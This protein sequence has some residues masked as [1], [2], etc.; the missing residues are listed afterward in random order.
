MMRALD[1]TGMLY[2][3]YGGGTAFHMD[4]MGSLDAIHHSIR[5]FHYVICLRRLDDSEIRLFDFEFL[6]EEE[7]KSWPDV[8]MIEELRRQG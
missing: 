8:A 7:S 1:D 6:G 3:G 4:G 5:G 2:V